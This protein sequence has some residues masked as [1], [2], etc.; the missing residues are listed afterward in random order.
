MKKLAYSESYRLV[1]K[2][3]SVG[4]AKAFAFATQWHP[5]FKAAKNPDSVKLFKAFG[6]AVRSHARMRQESL[7]GRRSA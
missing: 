7:V 5:E 3:K 6:D 1:F 4:S 2:R